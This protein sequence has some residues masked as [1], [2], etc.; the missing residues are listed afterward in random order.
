MKKIAIN[1]K[2]VFFSFLL[3]MAF[4][5]SAQNV[6]LGFDKILFSA[7]L[8]SLSNNS[9]FEQSLSANSIYEV[10]N[11]G[12]G[13]DLSIPA[14]YFTAE[15]SAVLN[16]F[17]DIKGQ[18]SNIK[19]QSYGLGGSMD[20][21]LIEED[22]YELSLSVGG[23]YLFHSFNLDDVNKIEDSKIDSTILANSSQIKLNQSFIAYTMFAVYNEYKYNNRLSLYALVKF[24]WDY[25]NSNKYIIE[26]KEI[27]LSPYSLNK[28]F[29]GIGLKYVLY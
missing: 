14:Y 25:A 23:G 19:I 16:G 8:S 1:M 18:N 3:A 5:S 17:Y 12:Y 20:Y 21:L 11:I 9:S 15:M 28:L 29:I 24:R 7:G 6:G 13:L 26:N 2:L 27:T 10:S 4:N 22:K